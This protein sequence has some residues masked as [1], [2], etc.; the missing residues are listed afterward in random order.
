MIPLLP[1]PVTTTRPPQE[2]RHSTARSKSAAMGPAMRSA[3]SRK[4][5][6][7]IRTTL[8][9][10][11][12]IGT[13]SS[14]SGEISRAGFFLKSRA[15]R[16]IHIISTDPKFLDGMFKLYV[17]QPFIALTDCQRLYGSLASLGIS[18]KSSIQ[19]LIRLHPVG[20]NCA[21]QQKSHTAE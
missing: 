4:A 19:R 9:P 8:E 21:Q 13:N 20:Q 6:A 11:D 16:G 15:E 10:V 5:S 3:R 12:F 1:I 14:S 7:S 17:G 2:C 18:E